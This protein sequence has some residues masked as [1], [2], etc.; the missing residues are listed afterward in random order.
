MR[1][2]YARALTGTLIA[3]LAGCTVARETDPPRTAT[4]QLLIST[5]A[6]RAAGKMLAPF[7][8]GTKVFVDA[9]YF[10]GLDSK[11]TIGAIRDQLGKSGAR[12]MA[13]RS[14]ADVVV[15]LRSAA[16]SIDNRS[17][18]FGIPSFDIPIPLTGS[19]KFPEIALFKKA[20][21]I[22]TARVAMTGF[23]Q[24]DGRYDFTVGPSTGLSNRT[25]WTV[26]IFVSW[27]T[28]D[29]AH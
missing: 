4:E 20:Q 27:T 9:Q 14:D 11:Y 10:E 29:L 8:P 28:D 7:P 1:T 5:A 16:Q 18:L 19:V 3:F 2:L 21:Q 25:Q 15:E 22:G 13:N 23:Q 24:K 12:L 17:T 6:D 26:L